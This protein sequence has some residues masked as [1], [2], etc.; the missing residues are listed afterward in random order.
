MTRYGGAAAAPKRRVVACRRATC[1]ARRCICPRPSNPTCGRRLPTIS[2]ATRRS[3][4]TNSISMRSS[5]DAIPPEGNPRSTWSRAGRRSW[6]PALRHATAWGAAVAAVVPEPPTTASQSR[7]NLLPHEARSS[8]A[9]WMRWQFWLPLALRRVRRARGDRDSALAEARVRDRAQR[10]GGRGARAGRGVRFAAPRTRDQGRRLQ[11]RARAQ[12]PYPERVPAVVDEVSTLLPDDT[13]LT[14][15]EMKS[16]AKGKEPQREILLR[17]ETANAGRLVQLFEE[18]HALRADGSALADHQDPARTGRDL[19]S[20][21]A[22]EAASRCPCAGRAA[23]KRRGRRSPRRKPAAT[24]PA[25]PQGATA[26][27]AAARDSGSDESRTAPVTSAATP[28]TRPASSPP[29]RR[30]CPRAQ[31]TNRRRGVRHGARRRRPRR[32]P[33]PTSAARH[34]QVGAFDRERGTGAATPAPAP[35]AAPAVTASPRRASAPVP[36]PAPPIPGSA[37][38]GAGKRAPSRCGSGGTASPAGT[39]GQ[40]MTPAFVARLSPP[41]QRALAVALLVVAIVARA[42]RARWADR[43]FSTGIT[44][45][46]SNETRPP[47]ALPPRG[48]AGPRAARRARHDEAKGRAPVLPQEHGAEPRGRGAVRPRA[49]R[50]REQRR[51]DHDQ[52]EPGSARGRPLPA[53]CSSTSS[54]S[55]PRR[56]WPRSSPR[57]TR[58][59]PM[60][61]STT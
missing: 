20:R 15:F 19:R 6:M 12:V 46:R 16:I 4:R 29:P 43:R 55:R 54:S 18:S 10:A 5:P 59:C 9:V 35:A 38:A 25:A 23:D 53:D 14:Q 60:S 7:L 24:T 56:R 42:D 1:C 8:R 11:L 28:T 57:S 32:R 61:S 47:R 45:S 26:R 36:P 27:P 58:R 34:R 2:T 39:G 30:Q 50:D 48:R 40:A 13:W 49:R 51:A 21:R 17:G 41:Q 31:R 33:P 37:P 44:T 3:R 22:V 52:P